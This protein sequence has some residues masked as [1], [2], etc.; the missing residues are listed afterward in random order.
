MALMI[1]TASKQTQRDDIDELGITM[2]SVIDAA[3]NAMLLVDEQGSIVLANRQ[4]ER[5]FGFTKSELLGQG[6]EMLLP[7][8]LRTAH[9]G[10]RK[11]YWGQPDTRAM[12]AGRDLFGRHK[13]GSLVPVEIGLNPLQTGKGQFVLASIIDITERKRTEE[14]FRL[15][16]EAAPNAMIMVGRDGG[17]TLVNSQAEQMFGYQRE[18]L[19]GQTIEVLVPATVR[20]HHPGMRDAFFSDPKA[21]AMGVGRDL[22][23]VRK[24]GEE[25]PVEIGLNPIETSEGMFTLASIIDITERKQLEKLSRTL[26]T[27]A[28]RQSMINSMPFSII[29][30]DAQGEIL[31]VN[32]ATETMLGYSRQEMVGQNVVE[33]IHQPQE[34]ASYARELS[35][36][37]DTA[38]AA[39][40]SV[41][42]ARAERGMADEHEWTYRRRDGDELPVHVSVVRLQD[43]TGE[44]AGFLSVAYDITERKQSQEYILHMAQHDALTGLPNRTLLMDRLDMAILQAQRRCNHVGVLMM[45]LDYFKRV[46]DT[47]GHHIGDQL[48]L[49]LGKRMKSSL[50]ESDTL[51][52]LGGDEF[53]IVVP[54]LRAREQLD[55]VAENVIREVSRPLDVQGHELFITP[56]LGGSMY[57]EG[58][59][60]ANELLK[61]AD[62]AMYAAKNAGR[63]THKWFSH[64][65]MEQNQEKLLLTTAL[66][67]ALDNDQFSIDYQPEIDTTSGHMVGVEALLRWHH[68]SQGAI[69]PSRFISLAEEAGMILPIGDWVLRTACCEI[70][71]LNQ[72]LDTP[73]KLAVNVSPR[74]LQ[75]DGWLACIQSALNVSGLPAECLELEI[76]EGM[77]VTRPEESTRKLQALR[78]LGAR[79]VVDDFGTGYSSL[80]YLTR[81]PIDKLKIDRSFVR[82]LAVDAKDAAVVDAIIAMAHSLSISV[83]AEGVET[84]QQWQYLYERGCEEL[85]G[86]Y[87]SKGIPVAD[88]PELMD[89]LK[90]QT[91][92]A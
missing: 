13:D 38:I 17:I 39:D 88:L 18:E 36:N 59:Q 3:P 82:D 5:L 80:S 41:I 10:Y 76:T 27:D 73:L 79:V 58:G 48:L 21:R 90:K 67:S 56:S 60:N 8:P 24:D 92:P 91:P 19:I 7:G 66:A 16:V 46:N 22:H 35:Q 49:Q 20:S 68:P 31:A 86:F 1:N 89:T 83:I 81:F 53:V 42:T 65:M 14:Q 71:Q 84:R 6:V 55:K 30:L 75:D 37:L 87:F 4:A 69:S 15:M 50:R 54:D 40:H 25:V 44:V 51:A 63:S 78:R 26:H 62:T 29:A 23:G 28:L 12:G 64:R 72:T 52:R 43:D 32:P 9:A 45:D 74:Q 70:A 61:N 57:P 2:A 77:L 85:Q 34:V 11:D 47:L 33:L